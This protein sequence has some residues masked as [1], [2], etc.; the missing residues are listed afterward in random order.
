M[1]PILARYGGAFGYDLRIGEILKS[2]SDAALNRLFVISFPDAAAREAF[3]ADPAYLEVRG[4][5]FEPSVKATHPIA[6]FE[7]FLS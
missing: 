2:R 6:D 1:T 3:F 5:H 7:R 4:A